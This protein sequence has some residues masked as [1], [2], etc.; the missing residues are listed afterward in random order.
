MSLTETS[1]RHPFL[2]GY[3]KVNDKWSAGNVV[4]YSL[5]ISTCLPQG[6]PFSILGPF[7]IK[8]PHFLATKEQ[9]QNVLIHFFF[10]MNISAV[11]RKRSSSVTTAAEVRQPRKGIL[12]TNQASSVS[13][14]GNEAGQKSHHISSLD[15]VSPCCCCSPQV[16]MHPDHHYGANYVAHCHTE[17]SRWR[18]NVAVLQPSPLTTTETKR[19]PIA[20]KSRKSSPAAAQNSRESDSIDLF[21]IHQQAGSRT[22]RAPPRTP[23]LKKKNEKRAGTASISEAAR[24]TSSSSKVV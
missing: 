12:K 17:N 4:C 7:S 11:V 16:M 6:R 15:P 10:L 20:L 24:T 23:P 5:M 22:R 3:S 21:H 9:G 1:L 14:H 2:Q 19:T 18:P 13:N 8:A